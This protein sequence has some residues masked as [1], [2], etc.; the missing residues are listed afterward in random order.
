MFAVKV[1]YVMDK[2]CFPFIVAVSL[3]IYALKQEL[4][5]LSD[6]NWGCRCELVNKS[7]LSLWV[8]VWL[9]VEAGATLK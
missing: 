2:S 3:Y 5:S 4:L 8:R 9:K 1:M 6:C 7:F